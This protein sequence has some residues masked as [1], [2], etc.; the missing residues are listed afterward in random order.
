MI[1]FGFGIDILDLGFLSDVKTLQ[2]I[3]IYG[4]EFIQ[5]ECKNLEVVL[6]IPSLETARV[7]G[8]EIIM[9]PEHMKA[10]ESLK[11][12]DLQTVSIVSMNTT[13]EEEEL[14]LSNALEFVKNFPNLE[15]VTVKSSKLNSI[16]W[17]KPLKKLR[18][19]DVTD[20]YISDFSMLNELST[21]ERLVCS[22][23]ANTN[24]KLDSDKVEIICVEN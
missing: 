19:L 20:N 23:N 17:L 14:E 5:R 4:D 21:L 13:G 15:V 24:V 2:E 8:A 10:N 12:L 11:T 18:E 1:N 9:D 7:Y 16:G 3:K 22:K 6:G